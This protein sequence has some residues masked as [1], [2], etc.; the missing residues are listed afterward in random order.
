MHARITLARLTLGAVAVSG[1]VAATNGPAAATTNEPSVVVTNFC[2]RDTATTSVYWMGYTNNASR[3]IDR[4]VGTSNNV[5]SLS[6]PRDGNEGQPTQFR[7]GTYERSVAI[8]VPKGEV[9]T[10]TVISPRLGWENETLFPTEVS[11]V[12]TARTTRCASNIPL[13]SAN[14]Q[15][16]G[17]IRPTVE[18]SPIN[19]QRNAA[20]RLTSASVQFNV[21]NITTACSDGGQ[22]RPPRVLWGYGGASGRLGPMIF[23]NPR[24]APFVPLPSAKIVRTD[25]IPIGTVTLPRTQ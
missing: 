3:R 22:P 2:Y 14:I 20:G 8:I 12:T 18:W 23:N 9:A 17:L 7:M 24:P 21:A 11:T 10:W 6:G 4:P 1:L 5:S 15:V 13:A 25:Q 16:N 19:E